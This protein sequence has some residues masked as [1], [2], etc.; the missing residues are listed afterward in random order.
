MNLFRLVSLLC[1]SS[2]FSLFCL[3]VIFYGPTFDIAVNSMLSQFFSVDRAMP[4]LVLRYNVYFLNND[5]VW[6]GF[7]Y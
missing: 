1:A 5:W 2:K 4:N 7:Q 6:T 3:I